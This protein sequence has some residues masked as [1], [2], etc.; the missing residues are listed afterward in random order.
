MTDKRDLV[1]V[2]GGIGGS[3][4]ARAL[5]RAGLDVLVL[6]REAEFYDRV[7]GEWI[8]PWGVR[9]LIN[10][11]MYDTLMAAGGHHL[12][13]QISY[14][15]QVDPAVAEANVFPLDALGVPGPLTI[16]H[17][18]MQNVSLASAAE[19]GATILRPVDTVSVTAGKRPRVSYRHDGRMHEV[20]CRLIVG[21]DGRTSS[22]RRQIG[23]ELQEDPID[24]LVAGLLVDDVHGWPEDLQS[25]GKVGDVEYLIFPQGNNKVRL[26][27]DYDISHRN[28]FAGESGVA[29]FLA[30]FDMDC[31]PNSKAVANATPIGPCR[32]NPSQDAWID[33]P[34]VEGAVLIGD[35][36]GYND[37]I[38]G[39]GVSITARDAR[40]VADLLTGSTKWTPDLF[41]PYGIER[42]ERMRRLRM[43]AKYV[44]T[45]FA[46]FG[47]EA[48]ARRWRARQRMA[49]NPE[50]REIQLTPFIGPESVDARFFEQAFQDELF[51]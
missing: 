40:T 21:A 34:W 16:E 8:P 9:E 11:A 49:E 37:P 25:I 32:S 14:D 12:T 2:G 15:E 46:R 47:P 33:N 18:V 23:L 1:I 7:R 17:V 31:V 38:I 27:V 26:Y 19:A 36:A 5:A 10:L 13:R 44:T 20:A 28:R 41:E 29:N 30:A 24:H 45:M 6:E 50:F 48:E 51:A 42:K 43:S 39:Q 4:L 35:A 22:V 3:F